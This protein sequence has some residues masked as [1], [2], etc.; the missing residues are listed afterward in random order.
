MPA[1]KDTNG[2]WSSRFYI[3]NHKG[4]KLRKRKRGFKTK[5]EALE[6]E[7]EFLSKS[8]FQN[9]MSFE[10]LCE[11]YFED[12]QHRLRQNTFLTKEHIILKKILPFF[13]KMKVEDI[14][15]AIIRKWQ[16]KMLSA[17]NPTSQK[18]YSLTYIKTIN[19]QLVAILNYA[20]KFHNLNENPCHKAGSIGKKNADEMSIWTLQ[21]FNS[22]VTLL[23][24]K[25]VS[26][27]GFNVLFWTGIRIGELLALTVK[28]VDFKNKNLK[29]NKSYQRLK[30]EDVVTEPKTPKS[31]RVIEIS[32]FLLEIIKEYID[33]LYEPTP[34]TRLFNSTKYRFEHDMK[35]YSGKAGLHRIRIHDLRHSHA[36][37]LINNNVNIL[38][39][40]QRLGHE[41]IETTLNIYSHLY[42]ESHDYMM[43]I[44]NNKD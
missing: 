30:G 27:T 16:G 38:A 1:T 17:I 11:I 44:L 18:K 19:N 3:I 29:I 8:N 28:D 6:Y 33:K 43:N 26:Y 5:K 20:V 35:L 10:S 21:E 42:K 32:D 31:K 36:S 39:V 24:H 14:S 4:E 37:F 9:T 22:F 25:P 13:K 23:K 40:S 34:D 7:R 41:K 12:L 15:P 2:T